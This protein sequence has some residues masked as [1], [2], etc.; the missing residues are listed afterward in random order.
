ML[1]STSERSRNR[2]PS[3]ILYVLRYPM[4]WLALVVLLATLTIILGIRL[5]V[6]QANTPAPA[7]LFMQSVVKRDGTLGWHQLCPALQAQMPL[8]ALASQV[9]E[10]RI[11]ESGQGLTLVVDYVGAHPQPQGG[12]IRV[13]VVTARRPNGW[14]G[15]R[16]YIVYTQARGCIG[17]VKNF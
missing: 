4:M 5:A 9:E 8:P 3:T 6:V 11:A 7:D 12:Q 13:Y 2:L 17:D 10:Q 15:Q 16:T 14:V 1:H